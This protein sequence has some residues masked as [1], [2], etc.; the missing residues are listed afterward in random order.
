MIDW[1]HAFMIIG[2]A[3]VVTM[4]TRALPFIAFHHRQLPT[5]I[6]YLG[7]VLPSS[8]IVI[9]VIYCLKDAFISLQTESLAAFLSLAVLFFVHRWRH[10]VLLS[11]GCSTFLYMVLIRIFP[12]I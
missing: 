1:I 8:I 2:V 7:K 9:L 5:M 6:A 12:L 3:S 11:I 10:Q 4:F